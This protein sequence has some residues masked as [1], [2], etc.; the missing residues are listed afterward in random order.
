MLK[1]TILTT[2]A[3]VSMMA[4]CQRAPKAEDIALLEKHGYKALALDGRYDSQTCYIARKEG[5]MDKA[6]QACVDDDG[7]VEITYKPLPF[8]K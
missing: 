1:K 6:Y 4:G 2:F 7:K 3:A 8:A 5:S